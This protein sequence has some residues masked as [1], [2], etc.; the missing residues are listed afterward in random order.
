VTKGIFDTRSG[1]GYDD[2][3]VERYH[4]PKRY[5]PTAR[6]FI[7]DWII[8]REPRA[9]GGRSGYVAAARVVGIEPDSNRPDL[10]YAYVDGFLSFD[11][12]VPTHRSGRYY[13]QWL[14]ALPNKSQVGTALRG[15]SVRPL[16]DEDFAAITLAGLRASLAPE[17]ATRLEL[18]AASADPETVALVNAPLEDQKRRIEQILLNRKIRDANFR[19]QVC[20]AYQDTCAVTG[21]R[22]INGSGKSEVQAAHIWAV[23]DGGPDV[24][25]NGLA[26]S[27]TVHWLFDRHLISLT[28]DYALLVSHNKVPAELRALFAHQLERIHL[29]K[30][31]R[32]WPHPAY[33]RRHREAYVGV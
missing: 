21:L 31:K 22:M 7:G 4:F 23:K 12:V 10:S 14:D 15:R 24:V 5:L 33:I 32:L 25:Q 2:D 16:L 29:P 30:D 20:E 28:D 3:I 27:G 26:L 19:Q 17:N 8:Y 11:N 13:E 9:G 6:R 18:D 1:S